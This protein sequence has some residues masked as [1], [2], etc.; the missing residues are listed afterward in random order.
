VGYLYNPRPD[1]PFAARQLHLEGRVVLH[2]L[3]NEN[4]RPEEMS[5]GQSSGAPILDQTALEKVRTWRFVPARHG[6][7]AIA[8]WV[9]V[10]IRFHLED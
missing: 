6:D 4:G 1:Y 5:I 10:P 9:N 7:K 2:V 8:H 3:V